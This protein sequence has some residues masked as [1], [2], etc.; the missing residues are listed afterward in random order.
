MSSPFFL[1]Q[2]FGVETITGIFRNIS[3]SYCTSGSRGACKKLVSAANGQMTESCGACKIRTKDE[4]FSRMR[5]QL[6]Q[7]VIHHIHA[8]CEC[9]TS[10]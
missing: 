4:C 3:V 10:T 1:N 5:W 6:P 7:L 9:M 2:V 8:S